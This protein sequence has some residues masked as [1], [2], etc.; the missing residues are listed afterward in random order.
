MISRNSDFEATF[1]LYRILLSILLSFFIAVLLFFIGLA[2]SHK[3][4]HRR[5]ELNIVTNP[6]IFRDFL[7]ETSEQVLPLQLR[8]TSVSD[9]F[10]LLVGVEDANVSIANFSKLNFPAKEIELMRD[11]LS[12][13]G[14]RVKTLVNEE[15]TRS[16]ILE[17]IKHIASLKGRNRFLFYYTGHGT[18]Y[19]INPVKNKSGEIDGIYNFFDKNADDKIIKKLIEMIYGPLGCNPPFDQLP[20]KAKHRINQSFFLIP[21]QPPVGN[22]TGPF[23]QFHELVGYDEIADSLSNASFPEKIIMIDACSAGLPKQPIFSP[24][25]SYF[26]N[27]QRQSYAFFTLIS[28]NEKMKIFENQFTPIVA[29]GLAGA[30]DDYGNG[31][32]TITAFELINFANVFWDSSYEN[33]GLQFNQLSHMIFGTYDIPITVISNGG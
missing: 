25:P 26:Y 13:S 1:S 3:S 22:D 33:R 21:Y 4:T 14:Y 8:T 17:W 31:D 9:G 11:C 19:G 10:A 18:I 7:D 20:K 27:I 12:E 16:N 29:L 2:C 24:L 5:T 32:G 6:E 23:E 28:E 30:A 15:A